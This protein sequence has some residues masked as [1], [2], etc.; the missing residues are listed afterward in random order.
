MPSLKK[1]K[2]LIS[3]KTNVLNVAENKQESLPEATRRLQFVV[4]VF[5]VS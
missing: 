3:N 1:R 5:S 4:E 2:K